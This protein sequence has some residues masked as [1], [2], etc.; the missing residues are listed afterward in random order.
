MGHK[1]V[2]GPPIVDFGRVCLRSNAT[3]ELT[4]T[5]LLDSFVLVEVI[6]DCRELRHSSPLAQVIPPRANAN[7]PLVFESTVKGMFH[8]PIKYVVNGH[9]SLSFA[10]RAEVVPVTLKLST[11]EL[12]VTPSAG[13]PVDAGSRGIVSL[14]N[15][16]NLAAKF[17]WTPIVGELGTAFSI[18]PATGTVEPFSTLDCEVVF[19]PSFSAPEL[20]EFSL[21]VAGAGSTANAAALQ[22]QQQLQHHLTAPL[23][24]RCIAR[25]GALPQKWVLTEMMER[26][27]VRE[28]AKKIAKEKKEKEK[29]ERLNE[30]KERAAKA[31]DRSRNKGNK[32]RNESRNRSSK[33]AKEEEEEEDKGA[34]RFKGARDK[35]AE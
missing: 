26:K 17:T 6:V 31:R 22:Q 29:E 14:V 32:S 24:L 16:F 33:K 20:G 13:L 8:R 4:V 10:V 35:E 19:H 3:K 1:V 11:N 18:R 7:I 9:H 5:N 28:E 34:K 25:D 21:Q 30:E 15:D 12:T 27:R 2:V 23:R